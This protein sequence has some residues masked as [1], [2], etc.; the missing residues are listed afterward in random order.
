VAVLGDAISLDKKNYIDI[1]DDVEYRIAGVQSYGKGIVIRRTVKGSELTMKKYQVIKKNQ[2]MWCKVD[3][4]NGAFGI[5]HDEHV[6]AL[7]STNMALAEIQ[8]DI[9]LPQFIETL[10][11]L[12]PFHEWITKYSSGST[13]RKY[14]TP[15]ELMV[16]I[17]IPDLPRVGQNLFQNKINFLNSCGFYSEITS[18]QTLL[19][20]LRQQILQEAIEGKLTEEFRIKNRE[21]L[22]IWNDELRTASDPETIRHLK[23]KVRNCSESAASLLSR[24]KT[25]KEQLVQDKKIKNQKSLPPITDEEKP[26]DLPD[27]WVWCR[28]G[29]LCNTITKGSSPKWQGV[30]YVNSYEKGILFITSKNVDNYKVD[31]SNVTFV[32]KSFNDI[33][34]RSI[35]KK[36]D[37]LTNIV[38][39]SIGRTAIYNLDYTANINQAV[40]ILR[41]EHEYI[42]KT[43]MLKI[44]N[45]DFI[46]QLMLDMQFSPGRANLS[47]SNLARFPI[48]LPSL[49]EQKAIVAKVEK[50]FAICDQ[51]ETQIYSNQMHSEQLMQA[52]LKEAFQQ[53]STE[54]V[55]EEKAI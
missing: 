27:G 30:N 39:A 49:P 33:E 6:G 5:T 36:G 10:F 21:Q 3:T 32:E 8:E 9:Y 4:K 24:I 53:S 23:L 16:K 45:A 47:M 28:L 55:S 11:Q 14:L 54:I 44:M 15:K 20:K 50:L 43:F 22:R 38:G 29:D 40:C 7:A 37:L 35:L 52:V 2:L 42:L 17:E 26:F 18:Q 51:L 46:I 31:L 1:Q 19:K 48:A 34:P 41:I 12:K 13:N 25:E